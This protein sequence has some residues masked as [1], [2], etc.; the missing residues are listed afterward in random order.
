MAYYYTCYGGM[1]FFVTQFTLV[2]FC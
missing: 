1:W 2:F